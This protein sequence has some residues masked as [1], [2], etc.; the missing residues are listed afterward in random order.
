MKIQGLQI[1]AEDLVERGFVFETRAPVM[2]RLGRDTEIVVGNT[3]PLVG[4]TIP[5]ESSASHYLACVQQDRLSWLLFDGSLVQISYRLRGDAMRAH[6]YCF[7]PAPF[8]LDLRADTGGQVGDW[9]EGMNVAD[10]LNLPRRS[11][12]RFEYDQDAQAE[13]HAAAHLHLN[14]PHCRIPMRGPISVNEFIAFLIRFF[15]SHHFAQDVTGEA[16]FEYAPS[17][18]EAEERSFHLAWRHSISTA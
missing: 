10:P 12:L 13:N 18:T 15:Y 4:E 6:R 1:L 3:L 7:I 2:R 17:I 16:K 9:I 8:D 5:A 14:T 11:I